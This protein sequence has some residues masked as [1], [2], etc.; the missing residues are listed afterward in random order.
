[1]IWHLVWGDAKP[2]DYYHAGIARIRAIENRFEVGWLG[3]TE[4]DP[5]KTEQVPDLN[6]LFA[7]VDAEINRL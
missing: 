5:Y 1:M 6:E 2:S 7:K 3:G 4:Q